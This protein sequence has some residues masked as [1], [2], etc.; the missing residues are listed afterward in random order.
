MGW[1]MIVYVMLRNAVYILSLG[2]MG[3]GHEV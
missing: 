1:C 3:M 2:G